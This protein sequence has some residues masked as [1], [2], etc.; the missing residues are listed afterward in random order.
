[1]HDTAKAPIFLQDS[2][3]LRAAS[4]RK[5]LKPDFYDYWPR[6]TTDA[7]LRRVEKY[8]V[9][10]GTL[11]TFQNLMKLNIL[12][13]DVVRDW[14]SL[15]KDH[16]AK[17]NWNDLLNVLKRVGVSER[18]V[19]TFQETPRDNFLPQKL[20]KFSFLNHSIS[21][22]RDTNITMP[23]LTAILLDRLSS[24]KPRRIVEVGAGTGYQLCLMSRFFD[25]NSILGFEPNKSDVCDALRGLP[26]AVNVQQ[27]IEPEYFDMENFR[28]KDGDLIVFSCSIPRCDIWKLSRMSG[29]CNCAI[30]FSTPVSDVLFEKFLAGKIIG[31]SGLLSD[32]VSY[33]GDQRAY[34]SISLLRTHGGVADTRVLLWNAGYVVMRTVEN[35]EDLID[36]DLLLRALG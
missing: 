27:S 13:P 31:S 12:N 28:A 29:R 36:S 6:F 1:M 2:D 26:L 5:Q 25:Q 8:G 18:V 23:G 15:R 22:Y 20:Q 3:I 7:I 33:H 9:S 11:L 21:I 30:V 14:F 34:Q 4:V 16:C 17:S 19:R 24:L 10:N 35:G 32:T